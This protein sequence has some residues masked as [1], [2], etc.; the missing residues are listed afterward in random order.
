MARGNN[1]QDLDVLYTYISN[2]VLR[3]TRCRMA[4]IKSSMRLTDISGKKYV[5]AL[6][7]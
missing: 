3:L 1:E 7:K 6:Y 5:F 4:K 2:I